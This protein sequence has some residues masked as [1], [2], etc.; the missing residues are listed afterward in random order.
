MSWICAAEEAAG[1]DLC[2]VNLL[3]RSRELTVEDFLDFSWGSLG[4]VLLSPAAF[5]PSLL[6]IF[7]WQQSS[8][9]G[10]CFQS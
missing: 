10:L 1:G 3:F 4:V 7:P 8:T 5:Q 6:P 9:L 2:Q